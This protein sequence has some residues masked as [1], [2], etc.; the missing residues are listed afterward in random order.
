MI[1]SDTELT[2][3]VTNGGI[4]PY[5]PGLVN[6]ASVDLRWSGRFR[7]ASPSGWLP[8]REAEDLLVRPGETHLLDTLETVSLPSCFAGLMTLKSSTGRNG[9]LLSHAGWVDPGFVG[10]LSFVLTNASQQTV[11]LA[12]GQM[13]TQIAVMRMSTEPSRDYTLTGRYGGQSEP[14]PAKDTL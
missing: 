6:P 13:L 14:T 4:A 1:L 5:D 7:A 3:W 12:R 11:H 9:F 8:A 10:T 2:A